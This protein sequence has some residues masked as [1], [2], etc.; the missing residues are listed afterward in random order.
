MDYSFV[1]NGYPYNGHKALLYAGRARHSCD[2]AH[3][4]HHGL[5]QIQKAL[6]TSGMDLARALVWEIAGDQSP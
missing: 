1:H 5:G 3:G 2:C 4:F 6:R